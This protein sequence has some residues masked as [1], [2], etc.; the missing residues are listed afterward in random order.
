V[1]LIGGS[2]MSFLEVTGDPQDPG[3]VA[4]GAD[5]VLAVLGPYL[6]RHDI[7]GEQS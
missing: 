4:K 1:W 3:Q 7:E 6:T 2:W 5:L